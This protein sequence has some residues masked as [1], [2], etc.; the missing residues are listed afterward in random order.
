LNLVKKESGVNLHISLNNFKLTVGTKEI[1]VEDRFTLILGKFKK[2]VLNLYHNKDFLEIIDNLELIPVKKFIKLFQNQNANLSSLDKSLNILDYL[3]NY[4]KIMEYN[5]EAFSD[6]N[7]LTETLLKIFRYI[8]LTEKKNQLSEEL[9]LSKLYKKSSDLASIIDLIK[10]LNEAI[11]KNKK[12]LNYLEEDYFQQKNQVDQIKKELRNHAQ[13]IRFQ[14]ETKKECFSQINRITR[15]IE[16][17]LNEDNNDSIAKLGIK[18]NLTNAEKIRALQKKAKEAQY[19]I[20]QIQSSTNE[21]K[22]K[23]ENLTPHY[24]LYKNDYENLLETIKK[25]EIRIKEV[26]SNYEKKRNDNKTVPDVEPESLVLKLVRN[27]VEI[28]DEIEKTISDLDKI[29][30]PEDSFNIHNLSDLTRIIEKLREFDN[31]LKIGHDKINISTNE[32]EVAKSFESFKK[33]ETIIHDLEIVLNSFLKEI[34]LEIL[35]QLVISN[36][37]M[38]FLIQTNFIR[39]Y[40]E[41]VNFEG[42]TTPEKIYFIVVFFLSIK[43]LLKSENILFSNLFIPNIYN[44]GGSIYRTIRKILPIF[45]TNDNLSNFKLIFLMSNLELKK[46]IEN[47]KVLKIEES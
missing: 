5:L 45:E 31:V 20:K 2:G 28:E 15:Q 12:E 30:I 42:L 27:S 17:S 43:I 25:D 26:K 3:S 8:F 29:S 41:K 21:T 36:D 38:A 16:G 33:F 14:N 37:N 47:L 32:K 39:N 35:Y 13:Q 7:S 34:H 46:E 6:F 19:E 22:V 1:L 11:I 40:K 9:E 24:E 18:V 10:K 4:S 44:K 23:L